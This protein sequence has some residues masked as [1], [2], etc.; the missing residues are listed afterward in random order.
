MLVTVRLLLLLGSLIEKILSDAN[1]I[2]HFYLSETYCRTH[3]PVGLLL[4]EL[5]CSLRDTRG[6]RKQVVRLVR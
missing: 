1:Y 5:V 6:H 2:E 4:Q 3:F